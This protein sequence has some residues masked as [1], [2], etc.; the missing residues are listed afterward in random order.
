M[1]LRVELRF[2]DESDF[3]NK[4]KGFILKDNSD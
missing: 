2:T 4:G 1:A 3:V